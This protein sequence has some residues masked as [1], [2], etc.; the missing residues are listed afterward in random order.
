MIRFAHLQILHQTGKVQIAVLWIVVTITLDGQ[1]SVLEYGHMVAPRWRW[2]INLTVALPE[3]AQESGA[4]AQ[5]SGATDGLCGCIVL[6]LQTL[7][8]LAQRQFDGFVIE[9]RHTDNCC[10]LLVHGTVHNALLGLF[11]R[12]GIGLE[13]N[14]M[15]S[16]VTHLAHT[17]QNEGLC[18]II[19]ISASTKVNL[20]W[21]CVLLEGLC[22]AQ[23]GIGWTHL[24]LGEPC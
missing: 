17:G 5:R 8:L 21:V 12:N 22:Y 13:W 16:F 10:V 18:V 11:P 20:L 15:E 2:Q 3:L 14:P 23:N 4:N 19:P 6:G 24:H 1:T 7:R 9:L